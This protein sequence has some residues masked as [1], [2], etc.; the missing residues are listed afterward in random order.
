M[1]GRR[2]WRCGVR[3]WALLGGAAGGGRVVGAAYAGAGGLGDVV[4]QGEH[5]DG[6]RVRVGAESSAR[7]G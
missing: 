1:S 4:D 3:V 5:R 2:V 6:E 7:S